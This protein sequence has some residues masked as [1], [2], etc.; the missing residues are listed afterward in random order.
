M[1]FC[2]DEL[3]IVVKITQKEI[4]MDDRFGFVARRLSD[5]QLA[6][7]PGQSNEEIG[8]VIRGITYKFTVP[9]RFFTQEVMKALLR[10]LGYIKGY[11]FESPK[12]FFSTL[13]KIF[14]ENGVKGMD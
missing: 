11:H 7:P 9:T 3:E 2:V 6:K 5:P 1:A 12:V 14:K 8:L 4:G 13:Q 10:G